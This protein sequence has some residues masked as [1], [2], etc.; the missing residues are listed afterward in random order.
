MSNKKKT[1]I[2]PGLFQTNIFKTKGVIK[3]D[4]FLYTL[5]IGIDGAKVNQNHP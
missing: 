5:Y 4:Y 2:S 3:N 1:Q